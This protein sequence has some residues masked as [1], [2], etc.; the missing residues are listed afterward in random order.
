M[1]PTGQVTYIGEALYIRHN[2]SQ[3]FSEKGLTVWGSNK[4]LALVGLPPASAV[5]AHTNLPWG[6][7]PTSRLRYTEPPELA[8]AIPHSPFLSGAKVNAAGVNERS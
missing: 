5:S 8:A 4:V 2:S 3:Q 1:S 6:L 7:C